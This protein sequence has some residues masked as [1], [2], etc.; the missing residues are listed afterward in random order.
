MKFD[1]IL[2]DGLGGVSFICSLASNNEKSVYP[3]I[4]QNPRNNDTLITY[5]IGVLLFPYYTIKNMLL[6]QITL[7][8]LLYI[9]TVVFI[10]IRM[11]KY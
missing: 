7:D 8:F 10:W 5:I 11:W 1:H 2:C 9:T 3:K 6:L 4:M